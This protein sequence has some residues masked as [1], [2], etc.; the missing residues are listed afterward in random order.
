VR[1]SIAAAASLALLLAL[2]AAADSGDPAVV[3]VSVD[4]PGTVTSTPAGITCATG[5]SDCSATFPADT[6]VQLEE[7]PDDGAA[8]GTRTGCD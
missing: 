6:A 1:A 3:S 2:P 5:G 7:T 8:L 4:G